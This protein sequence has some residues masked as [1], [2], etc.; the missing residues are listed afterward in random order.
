MPTGVRYEDNAPQPTR[1]YRQRAVQRRRAG[2]SP[3]R[4]SS[5]MRYA[6]GDRLT[7]TAGLRF[8]HSR[9]ISPGR[10]QAAMPTAATPGKRFRATACCTT[11]N[12]FSPRVGVA[13]KLTAD[14]R[15]MLRGELRQV[16]PGHSDGRAEPG[17]PGRGDDHAGQCR[18]GDRS[19]LVN[20]VDDRIRRSNIQIDPGTRAPHDRHLSIGLDREI[21]AASFGRRRLRPQGR[22]GLHRLGGHRRQLSRRNRERWNGVTIPVYVLTNAPAR[23]EAL[24]PDEPAGLLARRTT[25]SRWSSRN[26][27]RAAGRQRLVHLVEGLGLQPSSGTTAAGAQV[28]TDGRATGLVRAARHVRPRS[29][30]ADER[31]RP[32]A[33]RSAASVSSDRRLRRAEGRHDGRRQPAALERQAVGAHGRYHAVDRRRAQRAGAARGARVAAAVVTDACSI[34]A[35]R[36]AFTFGGGGTRRAAV[37]CPQRC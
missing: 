35:C 20:P 28:A 7:V 30:H 4:R 8:D 11:W 16:Q 17:S 23:R 21:A 9:A 13:L 6:F 27:D 19:V 37:R 36:R 31:R 14:G 10:P 1:G 22:P 29:E 15:T 33:Q 24:Q 12:V 26:A 2:S 3:R 5:P 18:S 32:P 34:S 25:A